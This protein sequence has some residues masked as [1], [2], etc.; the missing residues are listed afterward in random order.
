MNTKQPS[1]SLT[2]YVTPSL[3]AIVLAFQV[4]LLAAATL[5]IQYSGLDIEYN[6]SLS[7]LTTI[8]DPDPLNTVTLLVDGALAGPTL[9]GPPEDISADIAIAVEKIP[10]GGGEGITLDPAGTFDLGLLTWGLALDLDGASVNFLPTGFV[11]LV[12]VGALASVAGQELPYGLEIGDDVTVSF[13]A[14]IAPG[15]LSA[16]NGYLTSFTAS[17]TGE[18][19]G[20]AVPEPTSLLLLLPGLAFLLVSRR[21]PKT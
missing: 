2:R 14:Q 7:L 6:G 20:E 18:I 1:Y 4:Q 11:D 12:Y 3:L 13:S 17:G 21:Q 8:G 15:S 16:E 9:L 5:Q 10:V 19:S